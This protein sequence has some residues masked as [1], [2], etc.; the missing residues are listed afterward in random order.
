MVDVGAGEVAAAG[1]GELARRAARLDIALHTVRVSLAGELIAS[2]GCPP[3]GPDL[4]QRMYS[5][6][7]TLTGIA[8][9]MLAAEG[10]VGL[11]DAV[12]GHFPE[13][14]PFHPYLEATTVRHLL[15]MRGPH[16][17]TT[18]ERTAGRWLESWFRAAPAHPPGTL[19]TYDTSGSYVLSAL[20]ERVSGGSITGYLRPRLLDPLGVSPELRVLPGPEGIEHGGSGLICTPRDLLRIAEGL[21][22]DDV[23]GVPADYWRAA[24]SAQADT[25]QLTWG[26]T[27]RQG[28]GYQLWL[29]GRGGWLMFGMGGQI[30]YGDPARRL[31]VV[32]TADSQACTGGDQRLLD[33]VMDLLIEPLGDAVPPVPAAAGTGLA[34]ALPAPVVAG[35]GPAPA[36]PVVDLA[37]PAPAHDPAAPTH[38]TEQL[39]AAAAAVLTPLGWRPDLRFDGPSEAVVAGRPA[40]VTAGRPDPDTLD[41]RCD[42]H[43]DELTPWRVRL[44][45]TAHGAIAVQSQAYGEGA[46]P[47]WTFRTTHHP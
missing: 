24:T 36:P 6:A 19:F 7:K 2:A 43:G 47:A 35:Q 4:P 25:T 33:D 1:I 32:V 8:V 12:V 11:D 9:G 20:V 46:D 22:S 5:V 16:Q 10:K 28:Y 34:S 26:G 30:V 42:L 45:R 15:A 39:A 38:L 23:A 27:L 21:M 41:L 14:A 37:W 31:A 13:L 17:A 29:P 18:Y 40:V 3:F 44:S